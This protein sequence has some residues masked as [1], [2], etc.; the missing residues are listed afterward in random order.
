MKKV[1]VIIV[2]DKGEIKETFVS[3][4][5]KKA[6]EFYENTAEKLIGD[7]FQ[8]IV[9]GFFSDESYGR[10]SKYLNYFGKDIQ[11]ITNVK[12]N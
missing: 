3:E 12:I 11:W 5:Y 6:N 10:I 7:D 8:Y 4:S 1:N 2:T 9:K